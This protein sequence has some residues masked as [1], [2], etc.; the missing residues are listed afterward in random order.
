[1]IYQH[2]SQTE[3]YKIYIIMKDVKNPNPDCPKQTCLLAQE[4]SMGSRNATH[5][6]PDDWN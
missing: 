2:L 5:I 3:R 6:T 4:L 1:M